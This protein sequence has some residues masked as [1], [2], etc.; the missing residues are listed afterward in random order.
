MS[1]STLIPSFDDRQKMWVSIGFPDAAI[2]CPAVSCFVEELRSL[3]ANGEVVHRVFRL[4]VHPVWDWF[5]ERNQL[6]ESGFFERFWVCA[7]PAA[8]FSFVVKDLNFYSTDLFSFHGS[9]MLGGSLAWVL[10]SGG[11]Y[12][13]F[14]RGGR[15][16]KRLG[17][18][19]AVEMIGGDFD[20]A[21]VYHSD[22]PWSDFFHDVGLDHTYVAI[23]RRSRLVHVLLATDTD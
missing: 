14:D 3:Y 1:G 7:G 17:E 10:S 16:A 20:H 19:A 2:P 21:L 6:H 13:H 18:E 8:A 5:L 15:E 12:H 22:I 9:F 11:P 23:D 4:P